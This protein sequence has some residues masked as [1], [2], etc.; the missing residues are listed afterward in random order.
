MT[1][2]GG[3]LPTGVAAAAL[4]SATVSAG[5]LGAGYGSRSGDFRRGLRV[6]ES[7]GLTNVQ[8]E[9]IPQILTSRG[10]LSQLAVGVAFEIRGVR[11]TEPL[12][13]AEQRRQRLTELQAETQN[14]LQGN[15]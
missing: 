4:G 11:T 12:A 1:T 5:G 10:Q 15:R 14:L 3:V 9:T 13:K 8:E 6:L 7:V 2:R